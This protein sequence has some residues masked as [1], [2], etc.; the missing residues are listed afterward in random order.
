MENSLSRVFFG[1]II[2][3]L[4][5]LSSRSASCLPV[6]CIQAGRRS[7]LVCSWSFLAVWLW[8]GQKS[9]SIQFFDNPLPTLTL[10]QAGKTPCHKVGLKVCFLTFSQNQFYKV[11]ERSWTTIFIP[12]IPYSFFS[13]IITVHSNISSTQPSNQ[14]TIESFINPSETNY[15]LPFNTHQLPFPNNHFPT[16]FSFWI[17]LYFTDKERRIW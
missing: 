6:I 16:V 11:A 13:D 14:P 2:T 7:D 5:L 4:L 10:C 12:L 17:I 3:H 8:I 15:P 9:N 1:I